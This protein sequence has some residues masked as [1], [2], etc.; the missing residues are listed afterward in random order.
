MLN[1]LLTIKEIEK[2]FDKRFHIV[3]YSNSIVA[4]PDDLKSFYRQSILS[5]LEGLEGEEYTLNNEDVR[6]AK[7]VGCRKNE[8]YFYIGYNIAIKELNDKLE[9]KIREM[10]KTAK[11]LAEC[12]VEQ[13][14][15]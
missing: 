1:K 13:K 4:I 15:A 7:K 3:D 8:E 2:E 14:E 10:K 9:S 5:I 6:I 12:R 11:A